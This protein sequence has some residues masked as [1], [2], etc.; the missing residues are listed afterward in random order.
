MIEVEGLTV[1]FG[2]TTALDSVTL[3]IGEGVTGLFGQN[4]SGKSTLL[5]TMAGLQRP[6]SGSVVVLGRAPAARDE[7]FAREIGYA[8]HATGLYPSLTLAENLEL[9]AALHGAPS[10][11]PA[12]VME[13]LDLSP[14]ARTPVAELSAGLRRRAAVARA[15]LH[16]PRVLLLDEPYANLDDDAAAAVS[17]AIVAWRRPGRAAVIA[18]H[19]AKRVKPYA[20]A[21]IILTRGRVQIAGGYR[22]AEGAVAP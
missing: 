20:D 21:G 9:F 4:G 5:R 18:T 11:R 7:A 2:R 8:G 16:D 13:A 1:V 3:S 12:E 15:L 6:S 17:A 14:R 19:G 10:G 22:G